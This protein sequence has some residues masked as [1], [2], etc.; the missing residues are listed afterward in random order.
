[1][2]G[3]GK[4]TIARTVA[5]EFRDQNRLGASFFFSRGGGDLSNA[6]QFFAILA[7]QLAKKSYIKRY[8]CEAIA[9][10]DDIAQQGLS[11]QWKYLVLQPLK[12]VKA[13]EL[14]YPNLVLVIDALD[15][16]EN[17]DDVR[18]ILHLLAEAKELK[19]V[20][21]RILVS[22][23]PEYHVRLGLNNIS[24]GV[25]EDF[26]LHDISQ[27]VVEQKDIS[28]FIG[29][30]MAQIQK[31]HQLSA[32][33]PDTQSVEL[34]VQRASGLFIYAATVCRFIR[35]PYA[36]AQEQL[37]LILGSTTKQTPLQNLDEIYMQI[38]QNSIPRN[39]TE[40]AKDKL[41]K[42][43]QQVLGPIV[44]SFD[45]LSVDTLS[46]LL[47][48]ERGTLN[49]VIRHLHSVLHVPEKENSPIRLLHP[50]FRDFL[51]DKQRCQDVN[52]WIDEK[53][54]HQGLIENCLRLMSSTLDR[55]I[56][57]LQAPGALAS[58]V[59]SSILARCLPSHVQYACR[60]WVDHLQQLEHDQREELRLYEKVQ[61][62]LEIHLLHW[63]EALS[64]MGK[65]SEGILMVTNLQK[66][67]P[68][69]GSQIY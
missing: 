45:L 8:I 40:H 51:L 20:H 54:V 2:A 60:Y 43:F 3:M 21:L 38:L 69:G 57:G 28:V 11:N 17:Q 35:D 44:I 61:V 18:L 63:L 66:M 33:W 12:E 4:S 46:K 9:K 62:F 6:R 16:C 29:H 48:I 13:D 52:F 59:E 56:C 23:R 7:R 26:N 36:D 34:I 50:S 49:T 30:E 1:M 22:S 25:R 37:D 14:Q 5:R 53:K 24:P 31:E 42:R 68:V 32:D 39:G 41:T 27:S 64:I 65:M 19:A 10:D 55:D 58:E 47:S 67:F 15:E